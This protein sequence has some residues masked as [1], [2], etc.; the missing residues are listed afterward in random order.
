M[1]RHHS[2][3][4]FLATVTAGAA[5]GVAGCSTGGGGSEFRA[6]IGM[7]TPQSGPLAPSGKA[8]LRGAEI[9]IE[10]INAERDEPIELVT[11]DGQASSEEARNV[12]QTMIDNDVP[13]ITGTFSSAVSGAVSNLAEEEEIPFMTA[14]SVDPGITSESDEY[15]FRLTGDTNQKLTGVAQFFQDQGVERVGVLGA[16]YAL[17]QSSVDFM[18][19][20]ASDFGFTVEST[21]LVPL[22]TSDFVPELRNIDTDNVD[23]MFFPFPG[24]NGPT[25]VEQ[26]RSQG[27]YEE[28]EYMV[29]H[30]SYGTQLYR[31]AVDDAITGTYNWGVDISNDRAQSANEAMQ[32]AYDDTPQRMD[33][34]SL[35]N[36]DAVHMIANAMERADSL[37]PQA[38]RD[39]LAD[40]SYEAAS[41]WTVEFGESGDNTQYQLL[42]NRW[43]STDNGQR[44]EVQYET[45]VIPP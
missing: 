36:Y 15:T 10:E 13:V 3:R 42:L 30:D 41:G 17:G 12:S 5:A 37:T 4:E 1:A 31:N 40:A 26:F 18:N 24:G 27:I 38:V 33:A 35:P 34:L 44:N 11:E 32:E 16:D 23:A 9:A 39:E 14:I 20:N 21:S 2:R 25:L 8:G 43:T 22:S 6:A 19:G 28:V 45:D 29:G 7:P